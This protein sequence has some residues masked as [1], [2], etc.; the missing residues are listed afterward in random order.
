MTNR[1]IINICGG[2]AAGKTTLC[3]IFH[4]THFRPLFE[5]FKKSPFWEP[6]Y[7]NPGKYIFETEIS[8][9]LLHYHQMK[10]AIE[11]SKTNLICDFSFLL[12]RSYAEIGSAMGLVESQL[13]AFKCVLNE[14]QKE[15]PEPS[16]NVFLD[17]DA[18]TQ[19]SRIKNRN[20]P[21]ESMITV[22]FLASLNTALKS[23]VAKIAPSKIITINSAEKDFANDES[24]KKEMKALI[25]GFLQKANLNS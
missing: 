8:F 25:E 18:A 14:I 21:E 13:N 17:C 15:L 19:F 12:D 23:E 4:G 22:D 5:D 6:F 1:M 11:Q 3:S 9:I 10:K 20:R 16:L 7:T 2:I 24:V